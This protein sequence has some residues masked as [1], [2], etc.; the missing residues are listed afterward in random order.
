MLWRNAFRG[1]L[2]DSR[3]SVD[4]KEGP[5]APQTLFVG[6]PQPLSVGRRRNH[7]LWCA[8]YCLLASLRRNDEAGRTL[9]DYNIQKQRRT[10]SDYIQKA[11]RTLSDYIQNA[12]RTLSDYSVVGQ[13]A[14]RALAP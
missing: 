13:R 3:S 1:V 8:V 5:W 9:S 14:P 4:N 6:T 2:S 12:G 7:C 11:G 10:L